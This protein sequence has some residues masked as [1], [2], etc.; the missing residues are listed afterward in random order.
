MSTVGS[1]K[2]LTN[3][4]NQSI[5]ISAMRFFKPIELRLK[6]VEDLMVVQQNSRAVLK[7]LE[8]KYMET[9][10]TTSNV[11]TSEKINELDDW[12]KRI[13]F[14]GFKMVELNFLENLRS[15][16]TELETIRSRLLRESQDDLE[17][18]KKWF[19]V[20]KKVWKEMEVNKKVIPNI[21]PK[22]K[23]S[24]VTA[25]PAGNQNL[26]SSASIYLCNNCKIKDASNKASGSGAQQNILKRKSQ[27]Q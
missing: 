1:S 6:T 17:T 27:T 4:K 14:L 21:E 20:N 7:K 24:N 19:E 25:V 23:L 5:G 3:V 8:D 13:T 12:A 16:I 9:P 26:A 11:G 10:I 22:T 2:E 15:N 18:F